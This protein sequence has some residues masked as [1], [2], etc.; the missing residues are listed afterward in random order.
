MNEIKDGDSNTKYFH[1]KASSRKKRNL[2]CG[3][4]DSVGYRLTSKDDIER[5]I[6]AYFENIF[7]TSS[8]FG[9][10]EA[11]EGI[12]RLVID[13]MNSVLDSKPTYE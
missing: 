9:F 5:L 13:E 6:T 12:N 11:L 10:P 4:E 3:L 1:H 2:I 8:P 7:A